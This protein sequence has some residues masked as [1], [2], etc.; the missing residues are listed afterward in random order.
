M[1]QPQQEAQPVPRE[2]A[3]DVKIQFKSKKQE[4]HKKCWEYRLDYGALVLIWFDRFDHPAGP[5]R[6]LEVYPLSEVSY[7]SCKELDKPEPPRIVKP[8]GIIDT[9]KGQPAVN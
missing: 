9:Q 3:W 7:S 5:H 4:Y 8:T 2:P 6:N 1:S